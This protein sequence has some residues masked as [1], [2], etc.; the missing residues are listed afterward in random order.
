[1][2][3]VGSV[4]FIIYI[5]MFEWLSEEKHVFCPHNNEVIQ[6]LTTHANQPNLDPP[7]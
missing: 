1:M 4:Y 5:L 6:G 2:V 3:D 7:A